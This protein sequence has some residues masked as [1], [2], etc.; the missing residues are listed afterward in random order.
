MK[1]DPE[2][3]KCPLVTPEGCSVYEDRPVTCRYYPIGLALMHKP[4]ATAEEEFYFLIKEAFCEG[5]KEQK[6][7]T[8]AD[9][10]GDQGSEKYDERNRSWMEIILKRRSAG[11]ATSTS[12]PVSEFFYMATTNPPVFR[13]FVFDSTFLQRFK[14]DEETLALIRED[15]E[16][17]TEFAF[18]WLKTVLFGD[19]H[20]EM[21][22]EAFDMLKARK[23]QQQKE[24][25][26][27]PDNDENPDKEENPEPEK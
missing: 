27:N 5:H 25:Q 6:T 12:V 16:A 17:I 8:V 7:W 4:E 20:I 26:E 1:L 14:V 19:K 3:G 15:D 23:K 21:R 13:R 11:D 10:R 22:P 24:Q 2:T 18:A 9:W